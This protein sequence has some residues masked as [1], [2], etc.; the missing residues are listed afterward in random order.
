MVLVRNK[1][2]NPDSSIN[3]EFDT[4]LIGDDI[5]VTYDFNDT[6]PHSSLILFEGAD[7]TAALPVL[8]SASVG[9]TIKIGVPTTGPASANVN[10]QFAITGLEDTGT[11]YRVWVN[12]VGTSANMTDEAGG[13]GKNS[14]LYLQTKYVDVVAPYGTS[15][16]STYVAKPM[17]LSIPATSMKVMLNVNKPEGAYVDVYYRGIMTSDYNVLEDQV[18]T[19]VD[20]EY[21]IADN[22]D[23]QKFVEVNFEKNSVPSFDVCQ[24]KVVLRSD[25]EAMTPRISNLRVMALA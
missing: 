6:D 20:P 10:N 16:L 1:I 8:A 3:E 24:V 9:H 12:G 19:L 25:N 13:A 4:K 2:N 14:K 18:W 23:F 15:V 21:P 11:V 17:Q 22:T 7:Y 5:N